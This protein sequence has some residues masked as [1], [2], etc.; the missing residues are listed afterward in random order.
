MSITKKISIVIDGKELQAKQGETI[1]QCALRHDIEIPNLCYFKKVSHIAACRLCMVKLKGR[2]GSVPSCTTLVE[3]GMEITAFDEELESVRKTVLDMALSNHNDDCISC[4]QDGDCR[5]QDLAFRYSL[6]RHERKLPPIWQEIDKTSDYSSNVLDYEASKCIQCARCLRACQELQGK[7]IIDFVNRG[8]RTTVGTGYKDWASSACDG[9]GQCVQACPVGALTGKQI[10]GDRKRLRGKDIEKVVRTTCPYCGVGCQLDVAVRK[11]RIVKVSGAV[12]LPNNGK[13]CVKGRFG[14]DFVD[15]PDRL[16]RP[17]IKRDGK[18]VEVE[19]E[20]ALAYTAERLGALKR[21]HG[22]D[23]VAGLSSAR[24]TIEENFVFQKFMRAVVGTNNVDHCARLCHAS[25]VSGLAETL[26]SGAMTNSIAELEH[27]DVILVTGSNTTETH[28]VIATQ[29][30]RAVLFNNAKLIVVDP[31]RIDLVRYATLWLRQK[32]GTDTAWINGIAREILV[33]GLQDDAFIAERTENFQALKDGLASYTPEAVASI[34]GI[35]AHDIVE[36]ASIYGGAKKGS[37]VYAMGITQHASGTDNVKALANLALLT[38]NIGRESTGLNPLRGQ[39]NVQGACDMGALP[40]VFPGY[41]KVSDEASRR[42]FAEAWGV[43]LPVRPGLTLTEMMS[44][45][46]SGAVKAMFIMGENPM[47][48][49]PNSNHIRKS[50]ENLEFLVCQDIFLTETG[51]LAEVVFPAT[52]FAEKE[53]HY[54][55]TERRVL[56][57]KPIV[58]PPGAARDDWAIVQALAN[59]MGAGWDYHAA[60]DILS[61]INALTPQYGGITHQRIEKG[62]RL[63]WP[64]PTVDHKGTKFLHKEAFARGRGLFSVIEHRGARELPDEAYPFVLMTG[65]ILYHYHTGTMT[66]KTKMLPLY[67]NEA[68][69]EISPEDAK[70][71]GVANGEKVKLSS[72]RGEIEIAVKETDR[73]RMGDVFIPFHFAEAAANVLTNDVVDPVAKIP[74]L[75]VCAV[76]IEKI[77]AVDGAVT[78]GNDGCVASSGRE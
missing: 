34:S 76:R 22:P 33:Q 78:G 68:Y 2:A 58:S 15:R 20:E 51:Q 59:A 17:L 38:G 36:A 60:K 47:V 72:V 65:R 75:K 6:G 35:P 30:A 4:V 48:S 27:A 71:L 9:C 29:I 31:R 42:K 52:S 69:V 73:V 10:Y 57:V 7:G 64:C 55:N 45:A 39:N 44:G 32:S 67:V 49:D 62:E 1:L 37:I 70:S 61:E 54:T 53:G 46:C 19:W 28:P 66:R 23:A 3:E 16:R 13:T 14:L 5:L 11:D 8:I 25:T 26:G 56:P 21:E 24:C 77:A 18:L 41:Q 43:D 40:D 50:L 74:E 12:A 63:Q